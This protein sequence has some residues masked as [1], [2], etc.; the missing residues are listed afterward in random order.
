MHGLISATRHKCECLRVK[1]QYLVWLLLFSLPATADTT[2]LETFIQLGEHKNY[3]AQAALI[4]KNAAQV[5]ALVDEL[6]AQAMVE[7]KKF[8]QRMF[9]LNLA[10]QIASMHMHWNGDEKP[11]SRVDPIILKELK[12]EK[13]RV[14][15]L[16][17]WKK[18][19]RFLG[20]FVMQRHAKKMAALDVAPVLYPHWIH[21]I[22]Y[23]CKVCHNALFQIQRW[24]NDISHEEFDKGNLCATCHDGNTAFST[25][26]KATCDRCHMAGKPE[27]ERLH[28]PEKIDHA[29]IKEAAARI[30]AT[31][32]PE[33]LEKGKL[34]LDRYRMI[35]WL[36]LKRRDA[37]IPLVS[38]DKNFEE[39][40]RDNRILFIGKSASVDNV[41]FDHRIHSDW[42]DC[43][44]CHP[45]IFKDELGDN[46]IR[47]IEMAKGRFCGHCHGRVS[48]TFADCKRCHAIP[49]DAKVEPVLHRPHSDKM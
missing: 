7:G 23:E 34:P 37:F 32:R 24:S 38:L 6:I 43:S 19:E 12:I 28:K 13:A 11:L 20:N 25:K 33:N 16:M 36:E 30:G 29:A 48:F 1:A 26:D 35:D 45:A 31:W 15:E 21:R 17:K 49:R 42:I 9:L 47:M 41:L 40:T 2:L 10:S 14:D 5:P 8:E 4:E 44:T 27:A 3:T 18:Q 46:R 22:Y 39:E